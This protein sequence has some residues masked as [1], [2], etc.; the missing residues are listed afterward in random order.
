MDKLC[1]SKF[2]ISENSIKCDD[3]LTG[4]NSDMPCTIDRIKTSIILKD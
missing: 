1:F 3:E 2:M 4:K